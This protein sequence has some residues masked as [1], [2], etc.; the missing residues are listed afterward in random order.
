MALS[1]FELEQL[2]EYADGAEAS[3]LTGDRLRKAIII[4]AKK[5][6]NPGPTDAQLEYILRRKG[7]LKDKKH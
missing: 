3:G 7:L 5:M 1:D 2:D 4:Q 6:G